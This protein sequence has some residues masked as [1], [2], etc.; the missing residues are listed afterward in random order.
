MEKEF[1]NFVGRAD[2]GQLS[3]IEMLKQIELKLEEHISEMKHY[4]A[5]K[6]MLLSFNK[7]EYICK[8]KKR[9]DIKN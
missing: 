4:K 1:H 7:A 9:E 3:I 8:L 2:K 5:D 6:T